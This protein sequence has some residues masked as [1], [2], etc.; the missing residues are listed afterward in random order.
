MNQKKGLDMLKML[1][2]FGLIPLI[3]VTGALAI[4]ASVKM[5]NEMQDEVAAKLSVANKEFNEY[6]GTMYLQKGEEYFTAEGKDYTYV[7]SFKEDGV[8]FTVFIGD[9]RVMTSIKDATGKRIEGTQASEGVIKACLQGEQHYTAD[10]VVIN[11]EEY[12]VDYRPFYDGCGRVVG[13][14]FAGESN[15]KVM[16]AVN[17]V[18]GGLIAVTAVLF[19]IFVVLIIVMSLK[20]KAPLA[21]IEEDLERVV[22]GDISHPVQAKSVIY[23][24]KMM[25]QSLTNMKSKLSEVSGGIKQD[26]QELS[27]NV[28]SVTELSAHSSDAAE[29]ISSAMDDL[30]HGAMSMAESVQN[31]NAQML[32]MGNKVG[33]IGERVELLNANADQMRSVS[34]T[35][36]EQMHAVMKNSKSTVSAVESI[37]EQIIRT[38]D[39]VNKINEAIGLII[40]IANQ[41]QL[42]ALNASIE[43]ARAGEAGRGFAVVAD[44][45][46]ALSE[47]SNASA[48]TIR[49]IAEEILENSEESVE[50]AGKIRETI[51]QEQHAIEHAQES[52]ANLNEVIGENVDNIKLI[53]EKTEALQSIKGVI[54]N[55]VQDL[56]AISE[57]NAASNEEVTASIENISTDIRDISSRMTELDALSENLTDLIAFFN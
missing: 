43:A 18:L 1:L 12:Y 53:D 41:T 13:M 49:E 21:L 36:T 17:G 37:N 50:L 22:N 20:V 2:M 16:E 14:S 6:V 48:A 57:E 29:Q 45:I 33:E 24:N 27:D 28:S 54:I 42:L 46:S 52:F 3:V 25:I 9:T 26:A 44:S 11:G 34:D 15:A 5:R 8:E 47:Q 31:V 35:A 19:T 23:E 7:D 4:F 51:E 56:S 40:S 38:N 32:D 55:D 30:A 10:G 39:S